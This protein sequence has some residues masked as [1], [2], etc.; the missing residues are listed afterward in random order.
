MTVT[1]ARPSVTPDPAPA[2]LNGPTGLHWSWRHRL[3]SPE[4]QKTRV[5]SDIFHD[6]KDR[7]GFMNAE[8]STDIETHDVMIQV[9]TESSLIVQVVSLTSLVSFIHECQ[10]I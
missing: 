1:R 9:Y 2:P 4:T 3:M 7:R 10:T 8:S 5:T 6:N